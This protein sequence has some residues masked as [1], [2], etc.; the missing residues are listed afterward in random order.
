MEK[1]LI[2]KEANRLRH[3]NR[4][5]QARLSHATATGKVP[6]MATTAANDQKT[7][8]ELRDNVEALSIKNAVR[9]SA[10]CVHTYM[11]VAD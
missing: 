10:I 4:N 7:I 2:E 11:I 9:M 1:E 8:Q 3:E 5:I 6:V